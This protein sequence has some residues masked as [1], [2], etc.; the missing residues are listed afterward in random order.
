MVSNEHVKRFEKAPM[1]D[2]ETLSRFC[3]LEKDNVYLKD[4]VKY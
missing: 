1:N 4:Q 3:E 2:V